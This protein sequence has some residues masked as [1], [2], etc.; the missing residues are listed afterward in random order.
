MRI[1][2]LEAENFKKL[3]AVEIAPEGGVVEIR[4]ANGA[5]KS[6]VLDSIAAA[7]GGEKLC[8]A[9][10][11]RRGAKGARVEVELDEDLVIERRW[12][13][14]GG[15][16]LEVRSKDGL[17]HSSPQKLLDGLVGK[18]TFDP[19]A[20]LREVP[21]RQA[22]IL[23]QLVGIDFGPL[24]E[25]RRKLYDARTIANRQVSQLKARLAGRPE[26]AVTSDVPA[27]PVSAAELIAEQQ[28]RSEQLTANNIERQSLEIAR[29][30]FRAAKQAHEAAKAETARARAALEAAERREAETGEALR[31][32]SEHGQ[33]LQA[34]VAELVDP[35]MGEIPEKLRKL[36]S[37]NE[38]IRLRHQRALLAGELAAAEE[39]AQKFDFEIA[40]IDAQKQG[41][42]EQAKFPIDG[43]GFTDVGVTLNGLPLEQASSAEQLRVSLAMGAALNPKLRV[44]LVHDGSLLDEKSLQLVASFAEK[45]GM[46]V[47]LEVVSPG[48]AGVVI[49]DGH[50][51][52]AE[53][54]AA[55]VAQ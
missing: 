53:K 34:K 1:V 10:P 35:D 26:I 54:E 9:Q 42:L 43:L 7:I 37:V 6:S 39:E 21:T 23:R 3:V 52:G 46:Q 30:V 32:Q 16:R 31:K 24:E 33:V 51:Q 13:A 27:E 14:A 29:N 44:L 25:K 48:G 15:S 45:A 28:R 38:L 36:E 17:K 5:G 19:L 47:W 55:H 8:P 20:F 11:I 41:T 12:T 18:L 4:G 50:V 22:E 2:R 49:E 40:K